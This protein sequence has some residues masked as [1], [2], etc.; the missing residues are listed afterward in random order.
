M[1][2]LGIVWHWTIAQLYALI[3]PYYM[4][5]VFIAG[6]LFFTAITTAAQTNIEKANTCYE[7][8]DYRCAIDQYLVALANKSFV[9]GEQYILEYRIANAYSQLAAD[10]KAL[11]YFQRSLASKPNYFYSAWGIA[12]SYYN[13]GK[14]NDAVEHYKKAFQLATTTAEKESLYWA[15]GETYFA[16]KKHTEAITVYKNISSRSGDYYKLDAVI[17]DEFFSLNKYDSALLYYKKAAMVISPADKIYK[18]LKCFIG[19]CYRLQG[20]PE[21]A[22]QM[23]DTALANDPAYGLAMWEKGIIYANKMEYAAATDWYKKAVATYSKDSASSYSLCGNLAACFQNLKNYA[24]ELNWQQKRK[25]FS[26]N[27]YI[28]YARIATVQY[29]RLQQYSAAEKTCAEAINRYQQETEDRKIR[30]KTDYTTL[31]AIAGKIALEKKDTARAQQYFDAALK[32]NSTHFLANA[33][34]GTIAWAR[35]IEADYKKYYSN[36]SKYSY[37]TL[38]S[39]KNE[40]ATVFARAAYTDAYITKTS[41]FGYALSVTTALSFDSLQKEAVLLW[42]RVLSSSDY[43]YSLASKRDACLSVLNKAIKKYAADKEYVSELYNA[44]AVITVTTDTAAIH[45]SLEEAIRSNPDNISAWDN[46][47]KFYGSYDNVTGVVVVEKLIAILKKKKNNPSIAAA[48]VYKGDFLWR[49]N[50]K[51]DAKKAYQEAMVWDN[52]NVTAK[53]RIQMQ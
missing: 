8:K 17:G 22:M 49:S 10:E 26:S 2:L 28:E 9:E 44:K 35:K 30:G 27:P 36:V 23:Q 33:G 29:G 31:N 16:M 41:A 46:L 18:S 47:L 25:N 11:E 52:T 14:Y 45:K 13:I 38:L 21:L 51:D 5:P 20:K 19:K 39:S 50:K 43:S 42:P 32:L 7:A 6:V 3:K 1:W 12:D 48:Y 40:I 4:K 24:E 34:A 53:E 37:D 15:L